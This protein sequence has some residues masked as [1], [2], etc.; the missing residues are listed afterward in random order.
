MCNYMKTS[1]RSRKRVGGSDVFDARWLD[2][3][4]CIGMV[5]Q[6]QQREEGAFSTRRRW[7]VAVETGRGRAAQFPCYL[8]H[9]FSLPAH[10]PAGEAAAQKVWRSVKLQ[11]LASGQGS[12]TCDKLWLNNNIS[13]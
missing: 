6:A 7:C 13:Y 11:N 3:E 10:G 4:G 5:N 2:A 9:C 12:A 1:K 8:S